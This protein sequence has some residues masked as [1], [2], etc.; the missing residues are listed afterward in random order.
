MRDIRVAAVISRSPVGQIR[1]NL[2]EMGQWVRQAKGQ[3]AELVCFPE[4]NVTG[5]STDRQIADFAQPLDGP[6]VREMAQLAADEKIVILAGMA[7]A[8]A[9]GRVYASHLVLQPDGQMGVYRKL[10]LAAPERD[11]FTPGN[12]VPVFDVQGVKFGI[13][14]CYDGHFPE[15]S[16]CMAEMG[17]ELIFLPHASPRGNAIQKHHSWMRHLPARA[18]D[19][20]IFV[21]AC[22]QV[23]ENGGALIFPGNALILGPSGEILQK[24]VGGREGLLLADLKEGDL[25]LVR[26]HRMR[27]FFAHRRPELYHPRP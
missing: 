5:Y 14:L 8:A 15:L 7:E 2:D 25:N 12:Q 10:H 6:V 3:L 16:T 20:S 23:G 22:N 27:Y 13:Q 9:D 24:A 17:V 21:I 4:L 26:G 1:R 19:N 18:F 11:A